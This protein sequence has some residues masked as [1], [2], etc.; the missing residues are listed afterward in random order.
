[1]TKEKLMEVFSDKQ[2]VESLF[3]MDTPQE[4]QKALSEKGVD[5]TVEEIE[6]ARE[7]LIRYENGQLSEKEQ[8]ILDMFQKGEGELSDKD[9]EDVS[10]GFVITVSA[11]LF[12]AGVYSLITWAG[13]AGTALTA[14]AIATEVGTRGRW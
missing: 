12:G 4:V 1:M 13:V 3:K 7:L 11:L 5:V 6:Q 8:S 2:F 10:G 14:G 9:L